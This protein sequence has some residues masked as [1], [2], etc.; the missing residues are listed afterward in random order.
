MS[1]FRATL[2]GSE[3]LPYTKPIFQLSDNCN[4]VVARRKQRFPCAPVLRGR[5]VTFADVVNTSEIGCCR[6]KAPPVS[7][8]LAALVVG[9]SWI[10]CAQTPTDEQSTPTPP[11]KPETQSSDLSPEPVHLKSLPHNLFLDQKSFWSTPFHM[12]QPEWQWTVPLAFVGAGLL[13]TD[14]AI[15]KHA[16]T[17]PT[18]VSHANTASN[19]GLAALAAA[20]G[21]IFLWGQVTHDEDK[22]ETGFLSGEAGIDAFLDT[23]IFKYAFGRD[24]PFAGDGRG[25]FFEGGDSFPSQHAAIS[26]AIASVI[27]HEYTGPMT[28]LLAYGVAGGVSAARFA[29]QKHFATD[30]LV[31]SALGWY[32]GRQV[33]RSHSRY[34]SAEKAKFGTFSKAV[35]TDEAD[36]GREPRNM[37]SSYVPVDSWVYPAFDRLIALGYVVDRTASIRPWS[38]LEC[39]RVLS[40]IHQHLADESESSDALLSLVRDLDVEFGPETQLRKGDTPNVNAELESVYNR[41]T[42][43]SG[44]PLHDSFHFAQT[45]SD[46]FG[47]PYGHGPN[48]IS[49]ISTY[50]AAGPFVIYVRGE[51]QY[52]SSSQEYTAAQAQDVANSDGLPVNSVPTFGA[53]SRL[54]TVEAYAGLNIEGWQLTFGQQALW[55][56]FNRSTSLLLSNNAEAIPMLRVERVSPLRLPSVLGWLG[57]MYVS[58]FVGRLGGHRY[59][60]LGPN[61]VLYGDGI[62]DV[63]PQPYLWGAN[64]AFKPTPNLELGFALTA[65]FAGYGRPLDLKTFLHTFSQH[66]NAQPVDP[67]D[68]SPGMS[69]SYRLPG[70]RNS[71]L[72]Y[73]DSFSETQPFPLFYPLETA[74]NAG[75]YLPHVPRIKNLDFRCEGIY[76]NIPGRNAGNNSYYVNLHYAEGDRNYGQ[77]YT[78]WIG[79]GGNG[80]QA[81]TTYWFSGRNQASLTY[82]RMVSDAS[83]LKGGN[84]D[85]ISGSVTWM[86]RPHVE[87]AGSLQYERWN[88]PE[89]NPGPRSNFATTIEIRVWPKL[90]AAAAPS[91]T[92]GLSAHP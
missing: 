60:R 16:P 51:Y 87:F 5:E 12:T 4:I 54:R 67:G 88:F 71:V 1:Q 8:L 10:A 72:L 92:G 75:I 80:G 45:I 79:R 23:E 30:V 33:F 78:S 14:T 3:I 27:A 20:G 32:T 70:L 53:T 22:R 24:R 18:T 86:V 25:R 91:A 43:I 19:A 77:L 37:G 39:A 73:A 52:G 2:N 28:Q 68:R 15:E 36:T 85:D 55:W 21:G 42:D 64:I 35:E 81:S 59:L 46:D 47:R 50:A 58:G 74:L 90:R 66:G 84:V 82:R 48:N 6:T 9:C 13:A 83:L 40:E 61:S 57:P 56:G 44:P 11:Q 76:T 65:V 62:H 17:S 31:G 49:G 63:D 26:F 29:G 41:Y 89:L 34:S 38:R 7:W 69:A